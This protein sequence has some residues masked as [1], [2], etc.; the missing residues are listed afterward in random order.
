MNLQA[1]RESTPDGMLP[2]F[3]WPGGYPLVYYTRDGLMICARCANKPDTSDPVIDG[4]V[5][6]EGPALVCDD[7]GELIESAYGDPDETE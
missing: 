3:A 6:W 2:E 7:E 4:D 1:L 5:Y